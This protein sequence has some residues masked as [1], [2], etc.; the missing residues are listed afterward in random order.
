MINLNDKKYYHDMLS[1]EQLLKKYSEYDIFKNYIGEFEL[2]ETYK[3]PLRYGDDIPSFNIF[4]S[5]RHGCLLFKDFAGKRGD[6][7]VFVQQLLG[8]NSYQESINKIDEDMSIGSLT[9]STHKSMTL[10]LDK[11]WTDIKIVAKIWDKTELDWWFQ[12]GVSISTLNKY[13]VYPIYGYY[14]NDLYIETKGFAFAYVEE[15]D[16]HITYKI[17][18]PNASKQ[19]KWRT[20]HPFGVHQGYRQLPF[21]DK[22]L[23]ITKSLKDVMSI[24]ECTNIPAIGI[25]SETT[26]IKDSVVDEYKFRFDRVFT[27]FDNDRQGKDQADTYLK[28]Y[29]IPYILI[30]D[31]YECK[32]FSDLVKK[33][34]RKKAIEIF[35]TLIK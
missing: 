13:F 33:M 16:D 7:I 1:K 20:N 18:R 14:L 2:G 11:P 31:E 8:L 9:P 29:D 4:Y 3:S 28:L 30:P 35:Q 17:Y 10:I 23:I 34:G 19:Y 26:F 12:F 6:C 32:D 25:Q 27:L 24:W 5:K 22:I 21:S 15:K